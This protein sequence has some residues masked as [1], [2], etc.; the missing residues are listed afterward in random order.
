MTQQIDMLMVGPS[1]VGKTSFL[2]TMYQQIEK[3]ISYLSVN[4]LGETSDRLI[5]AYGDLEKVTRAPIHKPIIIEHFAG[6]QGILTH[7]FEVKFRKVGKFNLNITDIK[8]GMIDQKNHPDWGPLKDL[9]TKSHVIFNVVDAAALMELNELE[10]EAFNS[11]TKIKELLDESIERQRK[12]VPIVILVLVKCETYLRKNNNRKSE[13]MDRFKHRHKIVLDFLSKR[14]IPGVVVAVNTLGCVD[15]REVIFEENKPKF[16]FTRNPNGFTPQFVEIPLI[17]A[18][19]YA[20]EHV[21]V[22]RS[23]FEYLYDILTGFNNELNDSI[24]ISNKK[25]NDEKSLM[26]FTGDLRKIPTAWNSQS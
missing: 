3:V 18:I 15:F 10:N 6:N 2:A 16:L 13:L 7:K 25:M 20:L 1:G 26:E 9:S 4:P 11:P 19:S 23:I 8:G 14:G 5:K 22:N 12:S 24:K 17:I 21:A